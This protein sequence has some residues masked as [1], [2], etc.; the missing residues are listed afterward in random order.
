MNRR[1]FLKSGTAAVLAVPSALALAEQEREIIRYPDPW[2]EVLDPRFNRMMVYNAA[3]ERIYTGTRLA[4]L[5]AFYDMGEGGGDGIRCDREGNV[6]VS[7]GWGGEKYDGVHVIAP[8]G[9]L[10]GKICLPETCANLCFG[11][12]KRNRLF[13]T[14]SQSLYRGATRSR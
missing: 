4:N 14:A 1:E 6:W 8:D 7:A 10:I 3:V 5:R 9:K 11:G 13:M 2:M 12:T